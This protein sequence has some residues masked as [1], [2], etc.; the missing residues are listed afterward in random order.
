MRGLSGYLLLLMMWGLVGCSPAVKKERV[1]TAAAPSPPRP[2]ILER[3]T[4]LKKSIDTFRRDLVNGLAEH[5]IPG[6]AVAVVQEG[7]LAWMETFGRRDLE[8][9]GIV[10]TLTS[11]RLA[12]LSKGFAG[13]L[14]AKLVLGGYLRWDDPIHRYLPDFALADSVATQQLTLRHVLSQSTGLPHQAYSNLLNAGEDYRRI[15]PM[16]RR[17]RPAYPLG[18]YFTYQNVI[19]SLSGDVL[20]AATGLPYAA[21]LAQELLIP[22]G[23]NKISNG[24]DALAA[25]PNH[26]MPH[27]P[28]RQGYQRIE[29]SPKYYSAAPAAGLNANIAD[30]ARWLA[31]V[32]G[33]APK[34]LSKKLLDELFRIQ[35]DFV[36]GE[37]S[38]R[39]WRPYRRAG[40]GL[41]WRIAEKDGHTIVYHGGYVN[42]FRTEIAFCREHAIGLCL[43]SN[44]FSHFIHQAPVLFLQHHLAASAHPLVE[45]S[46]QPFDD[47]QVGDQ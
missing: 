20:E 25:T 33:Y 39:Q 4:L 10:D 24:F 29:L 27:A 18:S 32:Q 21:L 42:G 46:D 30:M 41:G 17:L 16:L 28:T 19:F 8:A 2:S 3:D 47:G 34:V 1:V 12:S 5:A 26:A 9:G 11:F 40:Y 13:A 35:V 22:L 43:L 15:V 36:A 23:M 31:A 44:G 37:P 14:A 7:E 45:T 38:A 6:L